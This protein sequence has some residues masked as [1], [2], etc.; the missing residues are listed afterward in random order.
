MKN[1]NFALILLTL[2]CLSVWADEFAKPESLPVAGKNS[3]VSLV[4]DLSAARNRIPDDFLGMSFESSQLLARPDG[5]R[6][7]SPDNLPLQKVLQTLGIK[8][9]RFGGNLADSPTSPDPQIADIDPMFELAR[10]AGSKVIYTI[11]FT[12]GGSRRPFDCADANAAAQLCQH[13]LANY[14][15]CVKAFTIGN[16]PNMYFGLL[17][18]EL[19]ATKIVKLSKEVMDRQAYELYASE[20]RK[21]AQVITVENPTAKFNGPSSTGNPAWAKWFGEDFAGENRIAFI[22][23]HYYPGGN[24]KTNASDPKLET[25]L[26]PAWHRL[27]GRY[28]EGNGVAKLKGR[29]F[30]IEECNSFYNGGAPDVSDTFGAALWVADFTRWLASHGCA[31]VNLHT[32]THRKHA[33]NYLDY[34][35]FTAAANGYDV[36]PVG[37]GLLLFNLGGKGGAV[38]ATIEN[39]NL[40]LNAYA[41]VGDDGNLYVTLI[42]MERETQAQP[43]EIRLRS[44]AGKLAASGQS[45]ALIAPNSD[46]HV[47][48]GI[49]LGGAAV[50]EDGSWAGKWANL[51]ASSFAADGAV[52]VSVPSSSALVMRL[53]LK[54]VSK[55]MH[56][57]PESETVAARNPSLTK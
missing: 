32:S 21:F 50:V 14:N 37:Y 18:K 5:R 27:Y 8:S 57:G 25:M 45:I 42:N 54:D 17:E 12:K 30:R 20:W 34:A 3:S 15:D 7:F 53:S 6:E 9:L 1:L 36:R 44:K 48:S 41:V 40:E 19:A 10:K 33:G 28:L 55:V 46:V 47:K 39:T 52:S 26:S 43:M 56:T 35:S 11:R 22:S 13:I 51:P 31:G 49:T 16:E 29:P 24:G 2:T 38:P 4:V 23:N